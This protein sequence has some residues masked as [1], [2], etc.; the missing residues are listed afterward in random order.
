[1]ALMGWA[2]HVL[3][4]L[5][6]NTLQKFSGVNRKK[7]PQFG[8]IDE[9]LDHEVG[10]ASNRVLESHGEF[11]NESCTHRPSRH[12]SWF[13]LKSFRTKIRGLNWWLGRSRNTV[14]VGEPVAGLRC[15][16]SLIRE[17]SCFARSRCGFDSRRVQMHSKKF[18]IFKLKFF[19]SFFHYNFMFR[20]FFFINSFCFCFFFCILFST[21]STRFF[22][23]NSKAKLN[24]FKYYFPIK[25]AWRNW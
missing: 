24:Y 3:Q 6:T 11:V 1:M 12:G 10:I 20:Y 4:W 19:Y 16:R 8:L 18:Y 22:F 9:I 13:G 15:A 25:R 21:I 5:A 7:L 17:N 23:F 2:T 14:A